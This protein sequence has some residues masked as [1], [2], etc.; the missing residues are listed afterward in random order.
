MRGEKLIVWV[1]AELATAFYK[2]NDHLLAEGTVDESSAT[3]KTSS[4]TML[5][6]ELDPLVLRSE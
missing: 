6:D 4:P 5:A 3:P 1:R 2:S